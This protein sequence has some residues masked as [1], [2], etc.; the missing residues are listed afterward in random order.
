MSL[1]QV[2]RELHTREVEVERLRH[3]LNQQRLG[4]TWH[5]NEHHVTACKQRGYEIVNDVRLTDDTL[6]NLRTEFMTCAS[7]SL[8]QR[9]ILRIGGTIRTRVGSSS[10]DEMEKVKSRRLRRYVTQRHA[11][12]ARKDTS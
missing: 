11:E 5:A 2:G 8:E 9:Q 6:S 10:H 3:R 7:Q 12:C 1:H 4:K